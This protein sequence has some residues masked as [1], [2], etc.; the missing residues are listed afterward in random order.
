[1]IWCRY[2]FEGKVSYGI[3]EGDRVTEVSGSPFD[4]YT[5]TGASYPL[6]QV[7]LLAP[8]RPPMLSDAGPN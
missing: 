4:E 1:M 7:K 6:D 2:Q 8:V 3:V 5:V